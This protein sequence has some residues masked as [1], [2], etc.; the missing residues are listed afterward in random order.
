MKLPELSEAIGE[1]SGVP[2]KTAQRVLRSLFAH[3]LEEIETKD[4]VVVP[5]LGRLVKR[6]TPDG[7]TRI[8]FMPRK[9]AAETAPEA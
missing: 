7:R 9:P 8:L 1:K 4:E 6:T 3:L 2:A 5:T